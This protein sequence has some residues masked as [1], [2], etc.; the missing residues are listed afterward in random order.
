MT[1]R[2]Y[3]HY[4]SIVCPDIIYTHGIR[5][6]MQLPRL[7]QCALNSTGKEESFLPIQVAL[8]C[9]SGQKA[10]PTSARK[11]IATFQIRKGAR[12][13]CAI[14]LRGERLYSFL[15]YLITI[16]LPRKGKGERV[17][18]IG[19]FGVN[20]FLLFPELQSHHI[21]FS[22]VGGCDCGFSIGALSKRKG[23]AKLSKK[24]LLTAFQLPP[25]S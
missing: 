1:T 23:V 24:A 6:I 20:S 17:G 19:N 12:L 8:Q 13:G 21:V 7:T 11:S 16:Y 3:T 9:I 14:N 4:N 15:D 18:K 25:S 2:M 5:N 10:R 22:G